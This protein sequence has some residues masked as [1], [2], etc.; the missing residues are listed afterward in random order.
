[1]NDFGAIVAS[2]AMILGILHLAT[3]V[4]SDW[5]IFLYR[6]GK[7]KDQQKNGKI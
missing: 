6:K 2:L 3:L 7:Y 4:K 1:M 5:G